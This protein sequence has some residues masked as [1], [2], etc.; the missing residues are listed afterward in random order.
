MGVNRTRA[1]EELIESIPI[2]EKTEKRLL[3]ISRILSRREIS[4][5]ELKQILGLRDCELINLMMTATYRFRGLYEYD[6]WNAES[7]R[8]EIMYGM[9]KGVNKI[10]E[11]Y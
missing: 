9:N 6:F 8:R 7:K 1:R 3:K 11:N 4:H 10:N 5:K 2:S